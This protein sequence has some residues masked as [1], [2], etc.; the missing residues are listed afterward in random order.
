[1]KIYY[2]GNLYE[3]KIF[4]HPIF[5]QKLERKD[6]TP[7]NLSYIN[8][9]LCREDY[10]YLKS[11]LT[12]YRSTNKPIDNKRLIEIL[13]KID[14]FYSSQSA[15]SRIYYEIIESEDGTKYGKEILSG[16]LFPLELNPRIK[17]YY[18]YGEEW[19]LVMEKTYTDE[20]IARF[21]YILSINGVASIN[22]IEKY[23]AQ[24]EKNKLDLI[25]NITY[26]YKENVFNK[27]II[28]KQIEPLK[29]Q[30]ILTKLMEDIEYLLQ[31]L[32]QYN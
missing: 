10:N 8:L 29:E 20:N 30:N 25:K 9:K 16:L 17:Y 18:G 22:D 21:R 27:Q 6:Y 5:E 3:N 1:M 23:K 32:K 15:L 13:N 4:N 19:N 28:E 12:D 2:V 24:S 26:Y 14:P 31:L 11:K 7:S